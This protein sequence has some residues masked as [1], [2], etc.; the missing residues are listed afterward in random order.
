MKQPGVL[1]SNKISNNHSTYTKDAAIVIQAAKKDDAVSKIVLGHI[2]PLKGGIRRL[3]FQ[4]V[5]AGFKVIV[6]GFS[7]QQILFIYTHD[8]AV[9][10]RLTKEFVT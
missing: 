8:E 6:R 9:R 1:R 2:I 7:N 5:P 3:K 4:K 10:N